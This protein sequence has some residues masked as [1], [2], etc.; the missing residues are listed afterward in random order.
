MSKHGPAGAPG[1]LRADVYHV[2]FEHDRGLA[3]AFDVLLIMAILASVLA[4]MFESVES[5]RAEHGA[6][7]RSAEWVFTGLRR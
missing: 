6:L 7:L 5:V 3:R 1:S 2:I 4:V